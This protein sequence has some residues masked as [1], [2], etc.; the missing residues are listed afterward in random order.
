MAS[1]VSKPTITIGIMAVFMGL[2]A[3][4]GVRS[5]M[6]QEE[7]PE[8][9]ATEPAARPHQIRVPVAAQDLPANRA[10]AHG[11]IVIIPMTLAQFKERFPGLSP[12]E[13]LITPQWLIGRRLRE[14][15]QQGHPFPTVSL[16]LEGSGPSI[17]SRLLPGYRA[18]RIEVPN[19]REAGVQSGMFVDVMFRA[20]ASPGKAG[21]PPIP[22]KTLT[23]LRHIE[24]LEAERPGQPA[25]ATARGAANVNANA[26]PKPML[27][28]LAVPEEKADMFGVVA[29]RGEL[30]LVPT[31]AE[32]AENP[33]GADAEVADAS[34][35]AELLGLKPVPPP[36]PPFQTEIYNRGNRKVN[37]FIDGKLVASNVN[38]QRVP[39]AL[40]R[41]QPVTLPDAAAVPKV[42][43]KTP[44]APPPAAEE[45]PTAPPAPDSE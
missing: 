21:Q 29:G 45:M 1:M 37:A 8:V 27:F 38:R 34:T 4:W 9:K 44:V 30:W 39:V 20:N 36:E 6:L 17:A 11:D 19:T 12:E 18:I 5:Y 10:V 23:L 32:N 40:D 41:V 3:A 43:E 13:T 22:E 24:V 25:P 16:Y 42:P 35:L 28:T 2:L 31:P 33:D 14:P 7:P 26:K 15:I